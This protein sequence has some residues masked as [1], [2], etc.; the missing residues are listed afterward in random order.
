MKLSEAVA[1]RVKE[2]LRDRNISQA[3]L[4]RLSTIH[5]G[6]MNDLLQGVYKTVNLKT[7]YLIIKAFSMK[8][9]EFFDHPIFDDDDMEVD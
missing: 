2:I 6:T 9:H 3:Q 5:H 4:E 7:V 8:V 1:H